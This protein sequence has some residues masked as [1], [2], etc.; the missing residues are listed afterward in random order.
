MK[1][2]AIPVQIEARVR[3]AARHRCGYCLTP[4]W[5]LP[6]ELE[7]EHLI[8]LALGGSNKE[9]DLWLSCR[10][11]NSFKGLQI[12]A[13][14]PVSQRNVRLF[15]PRRQRWRRHFR[16]SQNGLH[17]IGKTACGRAAVVALKLNN[18]FAVPAR[19]AWVDAGWHPPT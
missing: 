9:D 2:K 4:Q 7:L 5:L 16:W 12:I 19:R 15:N 18:F 13:F 10:A 14:D 11:C 17:I 6:L 3:Q 1:R 8:A